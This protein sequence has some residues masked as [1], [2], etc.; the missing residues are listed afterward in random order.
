MAWLKTAWRELAALFVDDGHFAWAIA[1]WLALIGLWLTH[2]G[3]RPVWQ[4]LI[5][6]AGLAAILVESVIRKARKR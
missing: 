3:L 5:L 4:A 1:I 6:F 2:V